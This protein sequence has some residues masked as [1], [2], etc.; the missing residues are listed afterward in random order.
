MH[1]LLYDRERSGHCYRVRLLLSMLALP[2]ERV[3]VARV[4]TGGNQ[5]S[6]DF[7]RSNPR[8]L[9]PMLVVDGKA[10]WDSTA[11]LVYLAR[12]FGGERWLPTDP[13]G[14]AEVTQ[15]LALAQ[16]EILYGLALARAH[17]CNR[18]AAWRG[19]ARL[20]DLQTLGIVALQ[21]LEALLGGNDWLA[22]GRPTIGDLA[23]FPYVALC[24]E[25]GISLRPYPGVRNWI[26]RIKTLPHYIPLPAYDGSGGPIAD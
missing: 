16:N 4:G 5:V 17:R 2:Y 3:D 10:I 20:I 22:V 1:L 14:M 26:G 6:D 9:V 21:A 15:W 12:R 18:Y 19:E 13:E 11:I 8:G 23:C 25:G 7:V 24:P